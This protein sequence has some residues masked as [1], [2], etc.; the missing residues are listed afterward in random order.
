MFSFTS[1][2]ETIH[3]LISPN[4]EFWFSLT[5]ELLPS[6]QNWESQK[7]DPHTHSLRMNQYPDHSS[8]LTGREGHFCIISEATQSN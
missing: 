8:D 4:A 5:S 2:S 7:E 1:N 6:E 3:G